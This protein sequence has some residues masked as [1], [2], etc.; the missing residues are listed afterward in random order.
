MQGV[1]ISPYGLSV[2]TSFYPRGLSPVL[3][4]FWTPKEIVQSVS[5]S[6]SSHRSLLTELDSD[7]ALEREAPILGPRS[8]E[9]L[10]ESVKISLP[11]YPKWQVVKFFFHSI[12]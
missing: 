12:V 7:S 11:S 1:V 4:S 5:F 3:H 8:N 10:V 9:L 2:R 6:E